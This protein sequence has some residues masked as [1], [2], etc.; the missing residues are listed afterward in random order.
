MPST[1]ERRPKPPPSPASASCRLASNRDKSLAR[2]LSRHPASCPRPDHFLPPCPPTPRRCPGAVPRNSTSTIAAP[3]R[4]GPPAPAS[5]DAQTT[6]ARSRPAGPRSGP[7]A[8]RHPRR[9][10]PARPRTTTFPKTGRQQPR[11]ARNGHYPTGPGQAQIGPAVPPPQPRT[12][13]P[14]TSSAATT[15]TAGRCA[16]TTPPARPQQQATPP[17]TPATRGRRPAYRFS[18]ASHGEKTP[19]HLWGQGPPPPRRCSTS[20]D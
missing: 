1:R 20:A 12:R 17:P 5:R 10:R 14:Q 2:D 7:A 4:P 18:R 19:S 15:S 9:R 16:A 3:P 13:P 11:S 6:H 8:P